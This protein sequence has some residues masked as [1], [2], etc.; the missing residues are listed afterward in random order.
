[1]KGE[2]SDQGRFESF[3]IQLIIYV[4]GIQTIHDLIFLFPSHSRNLYE[5]VREQVK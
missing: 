5:L 2:L 1:M 4:T 3:W